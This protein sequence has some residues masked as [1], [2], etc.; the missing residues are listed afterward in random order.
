MEVS[1]ASHIGV[2]DWIWILGLP[3]Y[4]ISLG[5]TVGAG[6]IP[7]EQIFEAMK[8]A[9]GVYATFW[10]VGIVGDSGTESGAWSHGFLYSIYLSSICR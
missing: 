6:S 8:A 2:G 1:T 9:A 10:N 7:D 4:S 5:F 3:K